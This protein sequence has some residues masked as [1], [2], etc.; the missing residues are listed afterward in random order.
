V[1]YD[2]QL[3]PGQKRNEVLGLRE[4]FQYGER[5]AVE[6]THDRLGDL[7]GHD[8]AEFAHS[9]RL[10]PTL[11]TVMPSWRPGDTI[12]FGRRTLRVVAVREGNL[13]QQT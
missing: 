9:P 8:V 1:S 11:T 5:T 10:P 3:L 2:R 13:K 4:V 12:P 6:C 7:I